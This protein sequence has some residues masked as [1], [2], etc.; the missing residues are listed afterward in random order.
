MRSPH[1]TRN[2]LPE[3][4][5]KQLAELSHVPNEA[6]SHRIKEAHWLP[7]CDRQ[8]VNPPTSLAEQVC[9]YLL[10]Y[11]GADLPVDIC[12]LEWWVHSRPAGGKMHFHFDRDEGLWEE[13]NLMRHPVLSSVLYISDIGGPTLI[14][15]QQCD[16]THT[17]LIPGEPE[18]GTL[19]EVDPNCWATFDGSLLHGVCNTAQCERRCRDLELD[20]PGVYD[21]DDDPRRIT[22]LVNFWDKEIKHCD[23]MA[24]SLTT[25]EQWAYG[26]LVSHKLWNAPHKR[27]RSQDPY[28]IGPEEVSKL[29]SY[30]ISGDQDTSSESSDSECSEDEEGAEGEH[31][32]R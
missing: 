22:L 27:A 32:A 21:D 6:K 10:R 15:H 4:L 12:G 14:V 7:V 9:E 8:L 19:F 11:G 24:H 23:D 17:S 25:E 28:V 30:D 29:Y 26:P 18:G 5:F 31:S 3:K 1:V 16:Q 2:V 20:D 13:E